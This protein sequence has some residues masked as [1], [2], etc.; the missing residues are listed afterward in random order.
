MYHRVLLED[1]TLGWTIS[2][3]K[4]LNP[5]YVVELPTSSKSYCSVKRESRPCL[6]GH[7]RAAEQAAIG[8]NPQCIVECFRSEENLKIN[9]NSL[10]VL[11]HSVSWSAFGAEELVLVK[12]QTWRVLIHSVS[13][14][15]FGALHR[16]CDEAITSES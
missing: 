15:A 10:N 9:A 12:Y 6:H 14:S 16:Y 3:P 8:C 1:M 5:Q 4:R 7:D 2:V 11:I 13:W